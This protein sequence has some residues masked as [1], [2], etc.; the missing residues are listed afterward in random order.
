M[1]RVKLK[2]HTVVDRVKFID[3]KGRKIL[4]L[5]FSDA[6]SEEVLDTI[7]KIEEVITA[8]PEHSILL[9]SNAKNARF[10]LRVIEVL[11]DLTK[12]TRNYVKKGAVVGIEGLQAIIYDALVKFWKSMA[13]S[14]KEI[15]EARGLSQRFDDIDDAKEY[16]V[17]D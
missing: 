8:Q 7:E 14:L 15:E 11:K 9:L 16:L 5:D 10:N 3:Y 12:K 17:E 4:Y 1:K 13:P 2:N 6:M